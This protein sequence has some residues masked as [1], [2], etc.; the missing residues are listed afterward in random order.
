MSPD[1]YAQCLQSIRIISREKSGLET[2]ISEAALGCL[3][4]HAGLEAYREEADEVI[5]IHAGNASGSEIFYKHFKAL[6]SK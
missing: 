3:V 6:A 5:T 1:T 2:I 4:R